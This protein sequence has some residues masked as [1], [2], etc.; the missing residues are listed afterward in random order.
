MRLC[1]FYQVAPN[2]PRLVL[3]ARQTR[4]VSRRFRKGAGLSLQGHD[5]DGGVW[6]RRRAA[7][8][9]G[10]NFTSRSTATGTLLRALM[11]TFPTPFISKTCQ[12]LLMISDAHA[13]KFT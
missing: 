12:P 9:R 4:L 2:V 1:R 10:T 11:Q 8:S 3:R 13:A 5:D 6:G 7:R